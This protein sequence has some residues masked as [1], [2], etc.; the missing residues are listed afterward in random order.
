M[1]NVSH[2]ALPILLLVAIYFS[3]TCFAQTTRETLTNAKII[4]M[5][6][7]GLGEALIV[8]KINQSRCECD[9]STAGLAKLK[10]AKVPDEVIS[11][12]MD[13]DEGSEPRPQNGKQT[14]S[15]PER[16]NN[17]QTQGSTGSPVYGSVEDIRKFSRVYLNVDDTEARQRIAKT[18]TKDGRFIVVND[19]QQAQFTL[20][21][22]V[23]SRD[24]LANQGD[25]DLRIKSQMD[26]VYYKGDKRIVAWSDTA[27][28]RRRTSGYL[29]GLGMRT[30]YNEIKLTEQFLKILGH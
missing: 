27:D 18:L 28:F 6:R 15:D 2:L 30:Q 20:E 26:A 10:A 19:P 7:L 14:N 11:A 3:Q 24:R 25:D 8:K 1:K 9:T 12:M 13:A 17:L 16:S 21:Y 5:V 22:K 4:E 29:M 23:I